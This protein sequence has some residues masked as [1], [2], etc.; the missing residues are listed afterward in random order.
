MHRIKKYCYREASY[1]ELSEPVEDESVERANT[2]SA[3]IE[4][5]HRGAFDE[6]VLGQR[7]D[8]VFP[9]LQSL[10]LGQIFET[11]LLNRRDFVVVQE[12]VDEGVVGGE[13]GFGDAAD[14][15]VTQI[16]SIQMS[17]ECEGV[18]RAPPTQRP[19]FIV[20]KNQSR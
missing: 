19:D 18:S 16:Q 9:Q 10:Q 6:E 5:L 17:A 11:L 15:V 4:Q 7:G 8:A 20:M 1:L 12:E 2:I 14:A 3:E 13:Q